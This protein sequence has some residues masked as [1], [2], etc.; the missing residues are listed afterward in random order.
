MVE[1]EKDGGIARIFLNRPEKVNAL[2]SEL[3]DAL[4][5]KLEHLGSDES[6]RVVVLAGRGKV[7]CAGADVGEL[8]ALNE[9]TAPAFVGRVHR[10]CTALR[11][12]PVPVVARLHGVVIGA[13]L[14]IAAACDLRI[15]A[16]GTRLAMP[17]VKLGIPSVVEAALL[18]RLMGSGRAAWLVLTGEAIDAERA[19]EW[20]LVEEVTEELDQSVG[21]VVQSLVAADRRALR[22]Q[23]QLLQLW[24]EAPL[25][26][27][28]DA[29]LA[30]FAEAYAGGVP[31]ALRRHTISRA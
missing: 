27:S 16:K 4:A 7:F 17:E 8:A 28:I 2:N 30:R 12:L 11:A 24:E 5:A 31:P 20:G 22:V 6:L 13:G 15:A 19:Y 25:G 26:R 1:L 3:L 14:E 10:A 21:R 29:S 23:K 18:P 9:S